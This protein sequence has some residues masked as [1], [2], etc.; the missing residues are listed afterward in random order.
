MILLEETRE[1]DANELHE[2]HTL[3]A[4]ECVEL[5]HNNKEISSLHASGWQRTFR[6]LYVS[7]W[8]ISRCPTNKILFPAIILFQR[9]VTPWSTVLLEKLLAA[10]LFKKIRCLL[11]NLKV[12][13]RVHNS[14]SLHLILSQMKPVHT[15]TPYFFKIRFNIILDLPELLLRSDSPT[16]R[17]C[18]FL[19][20]HP[21][22]VLKYVYLHRLQF[23]TA[24]KV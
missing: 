13:Y 5:T 23:I 1:C 19:I 2:V 7:C 20:L 24:F 18:A 6:E 16:K 9:S 8:R 10:Q 4:A 17:S 21:F 14:P 15:L 22:N 11:W 12:H 3:Y